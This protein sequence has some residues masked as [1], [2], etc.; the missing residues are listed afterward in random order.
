MDNTEES[1]VTTVEQN[2][3]DI[4]NFSQET[5]LLLCNH[6]IFLLKHTQTLLTWLQQPTFLQVECSSSFYCHDAE[7]SPSIG[8]ATRREMKLIVENN[9]NI[10]FIHLV[11]HQIVCT[12]HRI[13]PFFLNYWMNPMQPVTSTFTTTA[14]QEQ[15]NK[16]I[17]IH[18]WSLCMYECLVAAFLGVWPAG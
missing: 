13:L 11:V 18:C 12:K 4:N 17:T 6:Q 1:Q 14:Q 15:G 3:Y 5:P 2:R 7:D 10:C 16:W 9:R 8:D